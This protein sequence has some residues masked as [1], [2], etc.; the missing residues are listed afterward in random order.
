MNFQSIV[1]VF[2][3]VAVLLIAAQ[4]AKINGNKERFGTAQCNQNQ[5]ATAIATVSFCETENWLKYVQNMLK[6]YK[7]ETSSG[8]TFNLK[9]ACEITNAI[10]ITEGKECP[11]NFAKS[12]LPNY[13]APALEAM[14]DGLILNCSCSLSDGSCM[15]YDQN[16]MQTEASEVQKLTE[17]CH[18][19]PNCPAELVK[20]D[21][22]CTEIQREEAMG[23]LLPCFMGP[24]SQYSEAI[25][26]Y[27]KNGGSLGNI[28]PCKTMKNVLDQCF[29]ETSCFSQQEMDVIRNLVAT[30]YH[31]AMRSLTLVTDEFGNLTEFV[32]SHNGL[33]LQWYDFNFT[34][35]TIV[36]VSEPFTNKVLDLADY[37]IEDYNA[38]YCLTNQRDFETMARD[39]QSNENSYTVRVYNASMTTGKMSTEAMETTSKMHTEEMKTT[40]KVSTEEM[41]TTGKGSTDETMGNESPARFLN[42]F[43]LILPFAFM[44]KVAY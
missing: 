25:E 42:I 23:K 44:L 22:E 41:E 16:I 36:D 30:L 33:T 40:G 35:P 29:V 8:K 34:L 13:V 31:K 15:V 2:L 7:D 26:N 38:N 5:L 28:S 12:C 20:F 19:D 14:Y 4:V 37:I 3:P 39:L 21:K 32:D 43:L 11:V 1:E 17:S 6:N 9:T 24:F 18:K 27:F 10:A